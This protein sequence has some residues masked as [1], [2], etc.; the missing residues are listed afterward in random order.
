[1]FLLAV[2]LPGERTNTAI[3]RSAHGYQLAAPWN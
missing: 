1:V 3:R 2:D